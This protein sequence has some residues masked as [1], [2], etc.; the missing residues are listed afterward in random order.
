MNSGHLNSGWFHDWSPYLWRI[1]GDFG[2]RWYGLSYILAFILAYLL[3]RVLAQR[4]ATA[5]PKDRISDAMMFLVG[6]VIVGG[7]M[8]Y[9]L[10]YDPS[11]LIEFTSAIPFWGVLQLSNGGMS[12]HGGFLGV[13]LASWWISKGFKDQNGQQT[14]QCPALHV[15]DTCA[16]VAPLGLML[17]RIA[18][19][20][21]GELLGKVIAQP[22]QPAPWYA[23]RYPQ[24][25]LERQ[26]DLSEE[27]LSAVAEL[28]SQ[29]ML[30]NDQYWE[31]GYM[32]IMDLVQK[33]DEQLKAQLEPLISARY[34]T[35]L[36]QAFF[37]GLL[38]FVV[39]WFIARKPRRVGVVGSW[40]LII[41]ALGRIPMDYFRLPD[42][43]ISQFG[44][45][46]RGQAY[47][48]AMLLVGVIVL[49]VGS[50]KNW[51]TMG[52]WLRPNRDESLLASEPSDAERRTESDH[53]N[54]E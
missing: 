33:G 36:M 37:D 51:P 54:P 50:R 6:G 4:G 9:V 23:I 35:Q 43:G 47:S 14:G 29:Y 13:I 2:I 30:P 22:G 27:Q 42:S 11:L 19:F 26:Q 8:G 31:E 25:I 28:S 40:M 48:I 49:L 45:L 12:S 18:N 15:M 41:Y 44:G 16:L 34:P 52:G 5:I 38:V 21:N 32:R 17:G 46:T 3:L 39:V 1:S 7:R 10:L 53:D 24:E 20:I